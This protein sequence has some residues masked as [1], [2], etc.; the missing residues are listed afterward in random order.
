MEGENENTASLY[1]SLIIS[2]ITKNY[3]KPYN[4]YILTQSENSLIGD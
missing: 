4:K 3:G 2:E 1:N